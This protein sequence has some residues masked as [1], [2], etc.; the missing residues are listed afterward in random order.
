VGQCHR[1]GNVRGV[2]HIKLHQLDAR[3]LAVLLM[4]TIEIA[5]PGDHHVST[6]RQALGRCTTHTAS[7]PCDDCDSTCHVMSLPGVAWKAN[8]EAGAVAGLRRDVDVAAMRL[9][10]AAGDRKA[11]PGPSA[12]ARLA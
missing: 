3:L 4:G 10:D 1:I 8:G 11:K 2:G 12:L 5:H 9:H 6:P 7:G